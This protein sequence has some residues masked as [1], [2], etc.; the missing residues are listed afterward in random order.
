MKLVG[1]LFET[2]QDRV[3]SPPNPRPRRRTTPTSPWSE[4][5]PTKPKPNNQF[6]SGTPSGSFV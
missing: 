1:F 2:I 5:S 3:P 6:F 4:P